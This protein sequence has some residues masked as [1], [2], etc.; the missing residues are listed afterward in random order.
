VGQSLVSAPEFVVISGYA[1][2]A[3]IV[4]EHDFSRLHIVKVAA[5][6]GAG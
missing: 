1:L 4:A 6:S 2:F 5:A 3:A